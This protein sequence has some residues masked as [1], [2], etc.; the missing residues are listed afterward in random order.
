[1]RIMKS[2][3]VAIIIAT[4]IFIGYQRQE[5]K[6]IKSFKAPDGIEINIP[7]DMKLTKGQLAE[8]ELMGET[9]KLIYLETLDDVLPLTVGKWK[10]EE[11]VFISPQGNLEKKTTKWNKDFCEISFKLIF[12]LTVLPIIMLYFLSY[13]NKRA[14]EGNSPLIIYYLLSIIGIAIAIHF[15]NTYLTIF[16][17]W[18]FVG[19]A[20]LFTA[21]WSGVIVSLVTILPIG[22]ILARL[23]KNYRMVSGEETA[24]SA[25]WEY[26]SI[27]IVFCVLSF[28]LREL[29]ISAKKLKDLKTT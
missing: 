5:D 24:P 11:I 1:M 28:I 7:K 25:M 4:L 27:F 12:M 19:S 29:V 16:Y 20:G 21:G 15:G 3:G 18:L 2:I 6:R 10:A 13:L 22:I 23:S 8:L 14:G 9:R 17:I 26:V